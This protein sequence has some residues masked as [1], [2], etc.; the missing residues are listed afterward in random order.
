VA[1]HG[2]TSHGRQGFLQTEATGAA[3]GGVWGEACSHFLK[4]THVLTLTTRTHTVS[5][6]QCHTHTHT[7]TRTHAPTHPRTHAPT[8]PRTR[9]RPKARG[10]SPTPAMAVP[11]S[12]SPIPPALAL[13]RTFQC[14][15][16]HIV[17]E[18]SLGCAH[19]RAKPGGHGGPCADA[20]GPSAGAASC[21]K[22]IRYRCRFRQRCRCRCCCRWHCFT[23]GPAGPAVRVRGGI[24]KDDLVPQTGVVPLGSTGPACAR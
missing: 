9:R 6:T 3:F 21:N 23:D 18:R 5:H 15:L 1:Q 4:T 13:P 16:V 20:T 24:H 14:L 17:L 2:R 22:C 11:P 7:H 19:S 12:P 8:H 10:T